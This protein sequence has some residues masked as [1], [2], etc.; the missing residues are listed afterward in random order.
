MEHD[1]R[2]R[3]S[4]SYREAEIKAMDEGTKGLYNS[5]D[6]LTIELGF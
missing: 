6:I 5:Y 3:N 2:K 1:T 4:G